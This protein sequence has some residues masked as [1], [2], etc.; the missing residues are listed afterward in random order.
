MTATSSAGV[1]QLRFE[2]IRNL[3]SPDERKNGTRTYFAN[4]SAAEILKLDTVE[5]LRQYIPEWQPGKRNKMHEAIGDT[6]RDQPDEFIV[7]NSGFTVCAADCSVNEEKKEIRLTNG[8]LIN[9]A[10]S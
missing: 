9:G 1:V 6:I 5:N 4:I 2:S 10:Q 7:P 8:S 3:T